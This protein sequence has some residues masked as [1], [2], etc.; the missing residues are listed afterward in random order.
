M[1]ILNIDH[2]C[3]LILSF[4]FQESV[5]ELVMYLDSLIKNIQEEENRINLTEVMGYIEIALE[6]KDYLFLYDLLIYEVKPIVEKE[7]KR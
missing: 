7:N 3:N 2:I 5:N 6:N 4:K 1:L